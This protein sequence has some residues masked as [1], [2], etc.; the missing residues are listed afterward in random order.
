MTSPAETAPKKLGA[1][2]VIVLLLA[3]A[4]AVGM[5]LWVARA[6]EQKP[7]AFRVER[8]SGPA[9]ALEMSRPD[10]TSLSL[11][12]LRDRP[13]LLHFWA[14]WCPP[15]RLELPALLRLAEELE[16]EVTILAVTID[17]GWAPV[18]EFFG[19]PIPPQVVSVPSSRA[20]AVYGVATLPDSYLLD[21]SGD[22]RSR[23]AGMRDWDGADA[24]SALLRGRE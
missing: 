11:E 16:S 17:D 12:S 15:C 21:A 8:L 22:L 18:S 6:R 24:R 9:P 20:A 19:G 5:Y 23:M 1:R 3:Q 14:T 7:V 10:G 13:V 4:L 2:A